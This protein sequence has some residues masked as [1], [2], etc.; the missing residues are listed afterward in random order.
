MKSFVSW[1]E[2]HWSLSLRVQLTISQDWFRLWLGVEQATSHYLDQFWPKSLTY[3]CNARKRGVN[4]YI[5]FH[6]MNMVLAVMILSGNPISVAI[7]DYV[8]M[9]WLARNDS[10]SQHKQEG[11]PHVAKSSYFKVI[12]YITWREPLKQ[13][14]LIIIWAIHSMAY[15]LSILPLW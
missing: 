11:M 2:F 13:T 3:L 1:F 7:M 12:S 5:T 6:H 14:R 8:G 4:H 10:L 9:F 15:F